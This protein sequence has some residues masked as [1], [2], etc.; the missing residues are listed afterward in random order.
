MDF[1]VETLERTICQFYQSDKATQAQAHRI[2]EEAKN[3]PAAWFFVWEL[4]QTHKVN[5]NT[6]Y[7]FF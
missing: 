4:L 6:F 3:S 1:S 5:I 2:L 7:F